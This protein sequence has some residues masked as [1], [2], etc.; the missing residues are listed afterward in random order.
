M[1][2]AHPS[3]PGELRLPEDQAARADDARLVFIGRI[4]TPWTDPDACPK[5]LRQARERG[6]G[7]TVE[8]DPDWRPALQGLRA[9]GHLVLLYWMDRAARD[10]LVQWPRHREAPAGTF[11]LRSPARPNPIALAVV[12]L[13][14][15][16]CAG[17]RLRID[18]I[19]CLDRTPLL[20]IKPWLQS[21][22]VPPDL[23]PGG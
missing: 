6:Q 7:A 21:V 10:L 15:L 16:D 22:D 17:G 2:R 8:L 3:R 13:V 14:A 4:R 19:D 12:K 5:N 1:P 23:P 18:A 11:A 20:D 9:G